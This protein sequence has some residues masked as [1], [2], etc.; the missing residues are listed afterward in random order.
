M[1]AKHSTNGN[2]KLVRAAAY[3]RMSKDEQDHSIERQ[4]GQVKPYAEAHGYQI[5]REY[6]D[7]GVSGWKDG[8][9]RPAFTRIL[10]DAKKKLFEVILVDDKC[11]FSRFDSIDYGYHV[12]PLRDAGIRL[13]TASKG[14]VDW[15]SFE[16][17]VTDSIEQEYKHQHS[18]NTSRNVLSRFALLARQGVWFAGPTPYAYD[19]DPATGKL[20][21]GDPAQ[22]K[23]LVWLF[24]TYAERDVS[25][26]WLVE[27]LHRRAVPSPKGKEWWP[28]ATLQGILSNRNY[29]GDFHYNLTSHG[30]FHE[31]T[32]GKPVA[33]KG[34][35]NRRNPEAEWI[36]VPKSHPPLIDRATFEAVQGKLAGNRRR[37]NPTGINGEWPLSGLMT[38]GH[39]GARMIGT[40]TRNRHRKRVYLCNGY[41]TFGKRVCYHHWL[42]EDRL[43]KALVK[44]LQGTSWTRTTSPSCGR[45]CGGRRRTSGTRR[46]RKRSG[47][48][49]RLPTW[50]ARSGKATRTLPSCPTT[51]CPAWSRRSA[52]GSS[53]AASWPRNSKRWSGGLTW[54]TRRRRLRLR[55]RNSG[56][57]ARAWRMTTRPW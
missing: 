10:A 30:Q 8:A 48:G 56:G 37:T 12:K 29:L 20:T 35:R 34:K 6:V 41:N 26:R 43:V 31:L 25:L 33:K 36:I 57:C 22:V 17:R 53:S 47:C 27:E 54:Q 38:C 1:S 21:P 45:R 52:G 19:R 15:N 46:L 32:G 14:E 18:V 28:P 13:V 55:R 11:R 42:A 39:C 4:Q 2:G 44:K 5:V 24:K 23:V 49:G 16:G 50:T 7:E 51:V 9:Q 40:T 3:Y